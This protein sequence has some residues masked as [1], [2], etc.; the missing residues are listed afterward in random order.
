[1]QYKDI[2]QGRFI[3]RPNRFIAHVEVDGEIQVCHVKNTGRCRELLIPGAQV[4]LEK[5]TSPGRKTPFDLVAVQKGD[6][7]I[8]MDSQAPNKAF[9]EWARAGGMGEITELRHEVPLGQSRI[10]FMLK[11]FG[12]DTYVE[13][14]GVTLE[15]EGVCLFP[16]APT[17]RGIKHIKELIGA[18]KAGFGACIFLV[19]QMEGVKHFAP[20]DRTHPAFG[21]A[22]R[23]AREAGVDILAYD[24]AVT[25]GSMEIRAPVEIKL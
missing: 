6:R 17:E 14:K 15:K 9:A 18:R 24:C 11:R 7:L 10:D 1:M 25:P 22:L 19:I 5:G 23:E 8:N 20:N 13:V 16:D 21:Q 12:I 4:W 2:V 3:A